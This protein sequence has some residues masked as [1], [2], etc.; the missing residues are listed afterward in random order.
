MQHRTEQNRRWQ[1]R[2]GRRSAALAAVVVAAALGLSACGGSSS[3]GKNT[4]GLGTV[5]AFKPADRKAFPMLSGT[6][7][8]GTTLDMA[9]LKGKVIV[10]NTWGSWCENCREESPYLERVYEEYKDKGVAFVGI[11]TRDDSSQAKAFVTDQKIQYPSLV[12]GDDE[13]LLPKLVGIMPLQAVPTTVIID[14]DGKVA[15]RAPIRIDSKTLMA[16]LDPIVAEK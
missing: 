5:T 3:G 10:V 13:Q 6:A 12:D 8:D 2:S 14:R 1:R 11:D 9:S 16:G 15:W 7:L 4:D